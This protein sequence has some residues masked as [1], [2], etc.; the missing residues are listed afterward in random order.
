MSPWFV[1]MVAVDM[2]RRLGIA[3]PTGLRPGGGRLARD[4]E[5]VQRDVV[6]PGGPFVTHTRSVR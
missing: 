3:A 6:A 1:R 2:P 4:L 5:L